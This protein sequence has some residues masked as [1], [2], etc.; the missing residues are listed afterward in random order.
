M[1]DLRIVSD[2]HLNP[3][4]ETRNRKFVEFLESAH[5]SKD[6]VIIAGDLFD[7]W[8]GWKPL[9][10]HFQNDILFR[11]NHLASSGL[12]MDYIEGNR[13]FHVKE[14]EKSIFRRVYEKGSKREFGSRKIY[15]EHGDLINR[16]DR[17]YRFF[18]AVTKNPFSFFLL[19]HLPSAISLP[20]AN[21]IERGLKGTNIK[22]KT[23]YPEE[24][25]RKFCR[26]RFESGS[27]I[28]IVGHFH[29]EREVKSIV[30]SK[31]VV[32]YNLPGWESG[33]R[34]LLIPGK[35]G[36]PRFVELENA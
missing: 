35:E 15:I 12:K 23:K 18:R 11:M 29:E 21:R 5:A 17:P 3:G 36:D 6:E 30:N 8:L 32:F 20:L 25:C 33:F 9:T 24:H 27:D 14:Y 26:E 28:V 13:D 22:Y 19:G 10:F 7:L 31:A 2:L 34:Y 1:N 4:S 16:E